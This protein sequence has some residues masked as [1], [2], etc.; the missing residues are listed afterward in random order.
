MLLYNVIIL[1]MKA[2]LYI[3]SKKITNNNQIDLKI[4]LYL[5]RKLI[6][7]ICNTRLDISFVVRQLSKYNLDSW[8][9][10]IHTAKSI[11]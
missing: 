5:I 3:K 2:G 9:K 11:L 1:L 6:S 8:I 7:C 10:H 4:Y